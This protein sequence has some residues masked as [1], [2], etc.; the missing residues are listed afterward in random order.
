MAASLSWNGFALLYCP[1]QDNTRKATAFSLAVPRLKNGP[2]CTGSHLS[3][4]AVRRKEPGDSTET[5]PPQRLAGPKKRRG[6]PIQQFGKSSRILQFVLSLLYP[7]LPG[8]N[9]L[10]QR[11]L[12]GLFFHGS[13]RYGP[14]ADLTRFFSACRSAAAIGKRS[15]PTPPLPK[16][17]RALCL[18]NTLTV[19]IFAKPSIHTVGYIYQLTRV[20][21]KPEKGMRGDRLSGKAGHRQKSPACPVHRFAAQPTV[22]ALLDCGCSP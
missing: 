1:R 15:V 5:Q 3:L 2:V 14:I 17:G 4:G 10:R 9:P 21:E 19:M 12:S 8:A 16:I 7:P 6:A 18:S 13:L 11:P 22:Q 20:P